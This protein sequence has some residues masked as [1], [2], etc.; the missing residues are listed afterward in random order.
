MQKTQNVVEDETRK[1]QSF[2]ISKILW[3]SPDCLLSSVSVITSNRFFI[4]LSLQCFFCSIKFVNVTC[5][6]KSFSVPHHS[7][8]IFKL[9]NIAYQA[10]CDL[11]YS[12]FHPTSA[13]LMLK[14]TYFT[15][16][17]VPF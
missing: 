10:L 13:M 12:V 8:I 14:I 1:I 15:K 11:A 6:L 7:N 16:Y 5:Y 4:Q 17:L 9:F 3:Y 2:I